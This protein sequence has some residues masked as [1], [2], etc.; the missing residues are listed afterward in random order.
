MITLEGLLVRLLHSC[1]EPFVS[2]RVLLGS[3]DD[4]SFTCFER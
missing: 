1:N 4:S 3:I 2:I